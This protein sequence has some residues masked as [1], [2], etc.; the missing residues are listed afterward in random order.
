MTL[1]IT[2]LVEV[3]AYLKLVMIMA[4]IVML[5]VKLSCQ[6]IP[7]KVGHSSHLQLCQ[8]HIWNLLRVSSESHHHFKKCSVQTEV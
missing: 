7:S 6:K 3:E 8:Y 2:K 1:S 4:I 5:T